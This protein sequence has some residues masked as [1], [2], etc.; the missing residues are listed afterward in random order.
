MSKSEKRLVTFF[1]IIALGIIFIYLFTFYLL[2]YTPNDESLLQQV[3]SLT[4]FNLQEQNCRILSKEYSTNTREVSFFSI[5][6]VNKDFCFPEAIE[7]DLEIIP[8][9][10]SPLLPKYI[11]PYRYQLIFHIFIV[12]RMIYFDFLIT[13]DLGLS[14]IMAIYSLASWI[15]DKR[16]WTLQPDFASHSVKYWV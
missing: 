13:T 16:N 11:F 1:I 7:H 2:D 9:L 12:K 4:Q 15:G 8:A 14:W 6:E 10:W 5:I 3:N